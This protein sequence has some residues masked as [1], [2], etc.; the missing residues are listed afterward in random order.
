MKRVKIT[1]DAVLQKPAEYVRYLQTLPFVHTVFRCLDKAPLFANWAT[2]NDD[3][4]LMVEHLRKGGQLGVSL[5]PNW[6]IVDIDAGADVEKLSQIYPFV[7]KTIRGCHLVFRKPQW[8]KLKCETKVETISGYTVDYKLLRPNNKGVYIVAPCT[9]DGRDFAFVPKN[10]TDV[11]LLPLEFYLRKHHDFPVNEGERNNT[12][13]RI[14]RQCRLFMKEHP[15]LKEHE[16][17]GCGWRLNRLLPEPLPDDEI[18]HLIDNAMNLP[19]EDGFEE[20]LKLLESTTEEERENPFLNL[21]PLKEIGGTS[22]PYFWEGVCRRGDVVLLS[23]APKSGKSTF[24][25]SLALSTVNE[26][27]WFGNVQRGAVLWYSLEEYAVDIRDMV[28][29]AS[30]RYNLKTDDIYI[31][32]A[33]PSESNQPVKDFIEALRLHC[34]KVEP[35]LVIVDTVGRLMTGVDIN[36]YI[37]VGRFIESIRFAVRDIPSQPVILLVHHTNKSLER[38]PLGSQAFQ[39]SCDVLITIERLGAETSFT[40][41]GRGTHPKY[42]EKTKLYYDMGVLRKDTAVPQGV[43]TLVRLIHERKLND[44]EQIMN[45]G[46]GAFKADIRKMFR[47][48]LLYEDGDKIYTNPNHRLLGKYLSE[49]EDAE[50]FAENHHVVVKYPTEAKVEEKPSTSVAVLEPNTQTEGDDDMLLKQLKER[51]WVFLEDADPFCDD[52]YQKTEDHAFMTSKTPEEALEKLKAEGHDPHLVEVLNK[53]YTAF[54]QP[55][56][57]ELFDVN[58]GVP[59]AFVPTYVNGTPRWVA[60]LAP[61]EADL[62]PLLSAGRD[63]VRKNRSF[64]LQELYDDG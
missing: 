44:A 61:P 23:G 8:A 7:L 62:T 30:E 15:E 22:R 34:Q 1:R 60:F 9:E 55:L 10:E 51:G 19:D 64:F 24:V 11:P 54:K 52:T 59:V 41:I 4:E 63:A 47:M 31:V 42:M 5:K 48:G 28:M 38:T 12:L 29:V 26:T 33:N 14:L 45:Y 46:K 21:K 16:Y 58:W 18:M 56:R 36:D 20:T 40:A 35:A 50:P 39:G 3:E 57:G 32:E 25:R 2:Q 49:P 13:F 53:A 6:V 37:A 17:R 43:A 27:S